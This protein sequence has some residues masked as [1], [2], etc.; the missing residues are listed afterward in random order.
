M[1]WTRRAHPLL[2]T[3]VE[4][5]VPDGHDPAPA[6]AALEAVQ[7]QLSRFDPHSD[8]ARF[9]A[10]PAHLALD[11]Q[12]DTLEVLAFAWALQDR[13]GGAFDVS[14]GSGPQGWHLEGPRLHKHHAAVHLDLGGIGKGHAVDRAVHALQ[15]AGIEHGWVNAGGDLRAFGEVELPVRLRNEAD[16]GAAPFIYL[17][18]GAFATSHYGARS[19]CALHGSRGPAHVS[20]AAP[21]CRWADALTKLVALDL[22]GTRRLLDDA[23]A[24]AWWH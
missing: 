21:T 18:D 23:H 4:V 14:L 11:V 16:G 24:T 10:L 12:A 19:R 22:E 7:R 2:G 3:L 17:A 20:V 5:G 8:I 9:N 6:F 13:S 15:A 1:R